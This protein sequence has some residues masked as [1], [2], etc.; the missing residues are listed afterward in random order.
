M[1]KSVKQ[2]IHQ[3][4]RITGSNGKTEYRGWTYAKNEVVLQP[5]WISDN[6]EFRE[7]ELYKL[8]TTVTLNYDSKSMYTVPV[9]QCTQYT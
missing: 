7:P 5:G 8:L 4:Q 1:E 6:F 2:Q 9:G 3:I